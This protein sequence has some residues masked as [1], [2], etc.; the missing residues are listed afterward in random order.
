MRIA[1][2]HDYFTFIG[3]G[4]K[5]VLTMARGLKADVITTEVDPGLV[6]KMGFDDVNIISLGRLAKAPPL[7]QIQATMKFTTADFRGRYDF[8]VFSGNWAHHASRLHRPNLFYCHTPVRAFY[9]QRDKMASTMNPLSRAAF[10]SWT[11]LHGH[12]DRRSVARV[13]KIVCNSQNTSRR[14]KKYLGRDSV[15]IYPPCDTSRFKFVRDDGFWLS[16]NRLYPEKRIDVQV[17]AFR[18]MPQERLIIIGNSGVGDHSAEYAAKLKRDL[19]PNVTIISDVTED[20]L[21]DNYGRCRGLI[22]TATDEDFGMTAIEAMA[23]GKPVLAVNEGGYLETVEEGVTGAFVSCDA[24]A[25][26]RA[27]KGAGKDW[28]WSREACERRSRAFDSALFLRRMS[29]ELTGADH[30]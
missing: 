6:S 25:I 4:E 13:E 29:E 12:L 24:G 7:R 8:F 22:T 19:P 18:M 9:D 10:L 11:A 5:L 21:I 3:G 17:E 2:F 26:A 23:A 1:I 15:V 16:V 30:R 20:L 14:V 27:V 28:L